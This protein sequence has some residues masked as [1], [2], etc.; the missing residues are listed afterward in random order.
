MMEKKKERRAGGEIG[1]WM[2]VVLLM[3]LLPYPCRKKEGCLTTIRTRF[4]AVRVDS[5]CRRRPRDVCLL[6]PIEPKCSPTVSDTKLLTVHPSGRALM[7]P[8][9]HHQKGVKT[10]TTKCTQNFKIS[11][12]HAECSSKKRVKNKHEHSAP[13]T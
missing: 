13:R 10:S 9:A 5:R 4:F 6:F 1:G 8:P 2:V 11:I 12:L 3:M 7:A